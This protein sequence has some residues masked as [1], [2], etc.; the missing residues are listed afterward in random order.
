MLLLLLLLAPLRA[1]LT[2]GCMSGW[3]YS[4]QEGWC[5]HILN[6]AYC[7]LTDKESTMPFPLTLLEALSASRI[8]IVG[9][10]RSGVVGEVY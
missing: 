6:R 3:T 8:W 1:S 2:I 7:P 9:L 5:L 10:K 4:R